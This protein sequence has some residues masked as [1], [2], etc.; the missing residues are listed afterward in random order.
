VWPRNIVAGGQVGE[1]PYVALRSIWSRDGEVQVVI[2]A[3][4]DA[5]FHPV[6][7]CDPRGWMHYYGWPFGSSRPTTIFMPRAEIAEASAFLEAEVEPPQ[8]E[9]DAS[10]D[11]YYST[12]HGARRWIYLGWL[13]QLEGLVAA[14]VVLVALARS[15][16]GSRGS[17]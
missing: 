14:I 2:G 13:L 10:A 17:A 16:S 4:E 3:L 9:D 15:A 11:G 6:I 7:E 12:I 5:G 1:L 8:D